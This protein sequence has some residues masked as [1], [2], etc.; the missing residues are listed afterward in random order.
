MTEITERHL[1][2]TNPLAEIATQPQATIWANTYLLKNFLSVEIKNITET[3]GEA[4]AKA[5]IQNAVTLSTPAF[6]R[7]MQD[8]KI[9]YYQKQLA[10][11]DDTNK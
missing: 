7:Q 4:K 10:E 3:L 5:I 2:T 1:E 6:L 9:E 11:A 8:T